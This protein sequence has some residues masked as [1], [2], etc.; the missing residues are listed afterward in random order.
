MIKDLEPMQ[1]RVEDKTIQCGGRLP[2][3]PE[4]M[5]TCNAWEAPT[6]K[7]LQTKSFRVNFNIEEGE[8]AGTTL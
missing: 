6:D 4:T 2:P 5:T 3:V 7:R 8:K 1:G